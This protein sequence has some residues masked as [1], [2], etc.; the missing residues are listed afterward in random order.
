MPIEYDTGIAK[1]PGS[2]ELKL[3]LNVISPNVLSTKLSPFCLECRRYPPCW[4]ATKP[5]CTVDMQ[6]Y[7]RT[8]WNLG[9]HILLNNFNLHHYIILD[10]WQMTHWFLPVGIQL[11]VHA[12]TFKSSSCNGM[13][14]QVKQMH[15]VN[16]AGNN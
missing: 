13:F 4:V 5:C 15:L 14:V 9:M 1:Q 10:S 2:A 16:R 12:M 8:I 7:G 11:I 6:A 3:R